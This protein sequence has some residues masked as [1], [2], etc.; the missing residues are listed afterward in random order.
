MRGDYLEQIEAAADD[1][2]L[3][4]GELF[5]LV[6]RFQPVFEAILILCKAL[7]EKK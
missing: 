3:S 6:C 5:D 7:K 2:G 4:P 1:A